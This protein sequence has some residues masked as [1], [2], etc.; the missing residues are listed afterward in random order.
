MRLPIMTVIGVIGG[1]KHCFAAPT[2]MVEGKL[3]RMQMVHL[4]EEDVLKCIFEQRTYSA[5][6][7]MA[8]SLQAH[9]R[10]IPY[11]RISLRTCSSAET[12]LQVVYVQLLSVLDFHYQSNIS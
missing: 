3:G 11:F 1:G 4:K 9:H 6:R 12:S 2:E 5:S 7:S 8:S 10:A